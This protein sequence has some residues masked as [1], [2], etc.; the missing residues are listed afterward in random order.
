M[1]LTRN[2]P[3]KIFVLRM[4]CYLS[5]STSQDL[6]LD[7]RVRATLER[8]RSFSARSRAVRVSSKAPLRVDRK[9]SSMLIV[10]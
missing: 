8:R 9:S 10:R 6:I 1:Y 2:A 7:L 3:S 5:V 4:F